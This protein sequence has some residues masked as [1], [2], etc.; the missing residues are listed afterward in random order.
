MAA[1]VA[2]L[3]NPYYDVTGP[4]GKF[5]L[6]GLPPGDYELEAWHEK[7]KTKS[8]KITIKGDETATVDF[9]FSPPSR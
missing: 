7:L 8:A 5:T 1:Y 6:D 2:V 3:D 4:D 9:S